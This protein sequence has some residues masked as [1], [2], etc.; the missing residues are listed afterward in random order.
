MALFN[1]EVNL[2]YLGVKLLTQRSKREK[3]AGRLL[4]EEPPGLP[5]TM[6]HGSLLHGSM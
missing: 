3:N 4:H 2:R 5:W 6:L 1:L